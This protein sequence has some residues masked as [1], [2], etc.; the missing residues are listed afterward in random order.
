MQIYVDRQI[1]STHV[2]CQKFVMIKTILFLKQIKL[3][4][5]NGDR[6]E[7]KAGKPRLHYG[8][9]FIV[10]ESVC[11]LVSRF[12]NV[13]LSYPNIFNFFISS[14]IVYSQANNLNLPFYIIFSNA[15]PLQNYLLQ[16][17]LWQCKQGKASVVILSRFFMFKQSEVIDTD[18]YKSMDIYILIGLPY[19]SL[20]FNTRKIE[21]VQKVQKVVKLKRSF[22][23]Y[24]H[25]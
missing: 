1:L 25:S 8:T 17:T 23:K 3:K 12:L 10:S 20:T 19:I 7:N 6:C 24:F 11:K 15:L 9:Y 21:E 16:L 22:T 14:Y 5:A 2:G 18:I 4:T 13:E